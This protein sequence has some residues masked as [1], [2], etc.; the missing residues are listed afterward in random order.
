M[1]IFLWH[2]NNSYEISRTLNGWVKVFNEKYSGLN[3]VKLDLQNDKKDFLLQELKNSLQVNS[4][5]GNNKLII[6]KNFLTNNL[7]EEIQDLLLKYL[8][9]TADGFFLI[10]IQQAKPDSRKKIYKKISALQKQKK[11]QIKDFV[12]PQGAQLKKWIS[13]TVKK[14]NCEIEPAAIESLTVLT[15][16][17]LWQIANEIDKLI[18]YNEES[19]K[20]TKQSV[21]LLVKGKYDDDIFKLSDAIG[22][23]RRKQALHLINEQLNSGA[24]EIYLLSMIVRQFRNLIMIKL[25]VEN[26][27]ISNHYELAKK[28]SLHPFVAQKT[29]QQISNFTL[30]KLKKIYQRLLV[31]EKQIKTSNNDFH[32]L[33]D[34]LICAL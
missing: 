5:F 24:N 15:G 2:G 33:I 7:S 3:L 4:L 19:K 21:D 23:G 10:F 17:D 6:L 25:A 13:E 26:H 34:K 28:L 32:L 9:N 29:S 16:S 1:Q 27:G 8:D 31:I 20:I 12:S 30:E 22:E 11:A 18:F 14:R